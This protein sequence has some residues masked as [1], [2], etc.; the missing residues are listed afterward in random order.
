MTV[1]TLSTSGGHIAE[2]SG[3]GYSSRGEVQ[4]RAYK[5]RHLDVG[6]ICNNAN[7]RDDM[8]YGQPTEGALLACAY[9]NNMEDLRDRYTRLNEIP[10]NSETKMMVV[11]CAPKYGESGSE[12]VFV[13]G[14]TRRD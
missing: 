2:V 7:I 6:V 13:K 5:G 11:K 1:T 4:L 3:S 9:K 14:E 10:Y 8:L 12:Q